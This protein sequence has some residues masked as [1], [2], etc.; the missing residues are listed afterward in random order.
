MPRKPME[1][2]CSKGARLQPA[3]HAFRE[4]VD[5]RWLIIE[6]GNLLEALSTRCHKGVAS[7]NSNFFQGLEAVG[8]EGGAQNQQALLPRFRQPL[9]LVIGERRQPWFAGQT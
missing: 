4:K 7:F 9:E 6:A 1:A 3:T 2:S 5:V 8:H